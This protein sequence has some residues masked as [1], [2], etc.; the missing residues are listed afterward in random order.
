MRYVL[1]LAIMAVVGISQLSAQ[2]PNPTEQE[3][4]KVEN[5]WNQ[6][7]LKR[8][9]TKLER[10]LAD[11]YLSTDQEGVSW[12]KKQD[13]EID[14]LGA[15]RLAFFKLDDMKVHVYGEVGVVTGRNASKGTLGGSNAS[16]QYRFT[17]VFVKRDGRWQCVASQATPIVRR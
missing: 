1:S 9:R 4:I 2:M 12:N 17:D 13:I 16:S 6:A 10:F 14:T 7:V 5:D 3:L 15:S 11:E 8:D